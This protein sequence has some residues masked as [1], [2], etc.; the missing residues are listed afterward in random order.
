MPGLNNKPV[1]LVTQGHLNRGAQALEPPPMGILYVAQALRDAG[2]R[3]RLL[4][5]R[6]ERH[7]RVREAVREERPLFV[8][9]SNFVSPLLRY[10]IEISRWL[11]Q[12]GVKVVWGGTFS[13]CLPRA[14]LESG[15]VDYVVVGEG[16]RPA[17]E[18][19]RVIEDGSEPAGVPGVGYRR[20]EEIILN[21]PSEPKKD[22][23]NYRFGYD[24]LDW[25]DYIVKY[26]KGKVRLAKIP[27]S[28]GCPL[29]CAFCYNSVM[30]NLWRA[31][32]P[33]YLK[34]LVGFL[35]KEH[36][37]NMV[38]LTCDNPFGNV[39]KAKSLIESMDIRWQCPAHINVANE[40]FLDWANRTGC[41]RL[42]FG[43]ESGSDGMLDLMRKRVTRDLVLERL[44]LCGQ[45]GILT[46]SSWMF[47]MPGETD[48]DLGLTFTLMDEIYRN[49]PLHY[50]IV[51]IFR[52]YPGT[53]FWERSIELGHTAPRTL[54][55]WGNYQPEI[56][57]L[58]GYADRRARRMK[59]LTTFLYNRPRAENRFIPSSL[60][61]ALQRRLESTAM[62][63]PLEEVMH[64]GWRAM[65]LAARIL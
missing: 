12:E 58:L 24:L 6:G 63:G 29:N 28:R 13:T 17:V 30:G 62:Q 52:A 8:G 61:P 46:N 21:P 36:R 48:D 23:D 1:Y 33:E 35:K 4:H 39:K 47:F 25:E 40:D 50:M 26:H 54:E 19:A 45:K 16:E 41:V 9:F 60:R 65:N 22:I 18:L 7:K 56:N 32:S 38:Q 57:R 14:P 20:G 37:V 11:N 59:L 64:V 5:L 51:N 15:L 2:Y 53:D 42:G 49:N 34:D 31:H 43:V 27:F 55:Q 44:A 10:D 3:V